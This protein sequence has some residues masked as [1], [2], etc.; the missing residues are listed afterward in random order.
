MKSPAKTDLKS[1][2]VLDLDSTLVNIFGHKSNW[3]NV[4]LETRKKN[5][6]IIVVDLET[7]F[8]WGTKRPYITEFL[9]S[10]FKTFDLF[11]VWSAG[12]KDYVE[13]IIG[14]LFKECRLKRS[15]KGIAVTVPKKGEMVKAFSQT[16]PEQTKQ[17]PDY[18]FSRNDCVVTMSQDGQVVRQKPLSWLKTKI[19]ELDL[20]RTL[21]FDDF[22]EVCEQDILNHV[23]VDPWEGDFETLT[24]RDTMLLDL[25]KWMEKELPGKPDFRAVSSVSRK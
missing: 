15:V 7:E 22:Q 13:K 24:K 11:V 17:C 25:S 14:E 10:C 20:K 6:R 12:S 3:E 21:I 16:P 19:P 1:C 9:E 2:A 5:N 18:V 23:H 4:T 8:M